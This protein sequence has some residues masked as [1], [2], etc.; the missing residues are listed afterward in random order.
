MTTREA[1]E[2][3]GLKTPVVRVENRGKRLM[4]GGWQQCW[5]FTFADGRV[6][7]YFEAI[8]TWEGG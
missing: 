4:G 5:L 6:L 2:L 3:A 1:T 8:P 7:D